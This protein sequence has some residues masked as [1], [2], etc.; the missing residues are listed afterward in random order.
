MSRR[1]WLFACFSGFAGSWAAR[2][3]RRPAA[4]TPP[5]SGPYACHCR[6]PTDSRSRATTYVYDA[7]ARELGRNADSRSV[8]YS[9]CGRCNRLTQ[10]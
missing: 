10:T 2:V 5:A 3:R 4:A 1:H 9:Y 8:H 6:L 7:G